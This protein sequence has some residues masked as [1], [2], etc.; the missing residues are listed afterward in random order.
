[1]QDQTKV[2]FSCDGMPMAFLVRVTE[3][4]RPHKLYEEPAEYAAIH[5]VDECDR[6]AGGCNP[7]QGPYKMSRP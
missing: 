3:K 6:V 1:M 7:P 4:H 2:R 5:D